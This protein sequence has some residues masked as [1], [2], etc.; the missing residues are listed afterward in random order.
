MY[1]WN[2]ELKDTDATC[3]S[4]STSNAKTKQD[5][6]KV[7]SYL[8]KVNHVPIIVS[9]QYEVDNKRGNVIAAESVSTHLHS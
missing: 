5:V 3:L 6:I 9:F 1:N 4:K 2:V 8:S 7:N